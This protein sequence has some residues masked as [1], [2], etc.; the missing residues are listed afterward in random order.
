MEFR[1]AKNNQ[2]TFDQVLFE[3][4]EFYASQLIV[5]SLN[6]IFTHSLTLVSAPI[7]YG[8]VA[9][10]RRFLECTNAD[11]LW[12]RT[13]KQTL[14]DLW[15]RLCSELGQISPQLSE[16]LKLMK[17]NG[18][19][20]PLEVASAVESYLEI[21]TP[22]VI[23]LEGVH[24]VKGKII[25]LLIE[26]VKLRVRN[27]HIVLLADSFFP[28]DSEMLL[29]GLINHITPETLALNRQ[30]IM[31][32][33][34]AAQISLTEQETDF[35]LDYS[36]GW[37]AAIRFLIMCHR[38]QPSLSLLRPDDYDEPFLKAFEQEIVR[39]M[40][41][42]FI[43][44]LSYLADFTD[45][46]LE[47]AE[48]FQA[49]ESPAGESVLTILQMM[50]D[51][52][53]FI[54]YPPLDRRYRLHP[55]F[56]RVIQR[57]LIPSLPAT[58]F[59]EVCTRLGI[60]Y[61]RKTQYD[62]ALRC[63][64]QTGDDFAC[65]RVLCMIKR[66]QDLS[67]TPAIILKLFITFREAMMMNDRKQLSLPPAHDVLI[68]LVRYA[69]LLGDQTLYDEILTWIDSSKKDLIPSEIL[70][71]YE[72]MRGLVPSQLHGKLLTIDD[73]KELA[74]LSSCFDIS[75]GATSLLFAL[76]EGVH[77]S[78]KREVLWKELAGEEIRSG[79][80]L[81]GAS[82]LLY[83]EKQ[84]M[85][86]SFVEAEIYLHA[87]IR[88][89][90]LAGN[91]GVWITACCTLARVLCVQGNMQ[92]AVKLLHEVRQELKQEGPSRLDATVDLCEFSL[93]ALQG[94]SAPENLFDEGEATLRL[95]TPALRELGCLKHLMLLNEGRFIEYI[96]QYMEEEQ[97]MPH[98]SPL[99]RVICGIGLAKA[100]EKV[101]QSQG[102]T[103]ALF[104]T[105]RI[106]REE[107]LYTPLIPFRNW[108]CTLPWKREDT[109]L[110]ETIKKLDA[111]CAGIPSGY[112]EIKDAENAPIAA[113]TLLTR[114]EAE[115]AGCLNEGLSNRE[116]AQ[117]LCISEN[118]VKSTL[119]KI[120]AKLGI[121]SRHAFVRAY[122][123]GP[124]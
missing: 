96:S 99:R 43:S 88:S 71:L 93:Y 70:H 52:F 97:N 27:L 54:S 121:S 25:N 80:L 87:A 38:S 103:E 109:L 5:S 53:H 34:Q 6:A 105:L 32:V 92:D 18:E 3:S 95:Y 85:A 21:F 100:R 73:E 55:I 118:T 122:F 98:Y 91:P 77:D 42:P 17:Q 86:G 110:I 44:L 82:A 62:S 106:A 22:L 111:I 101:G 48:F 12:Y 56:R 60:W 26:V 10:V 63:Y 11:V 123:P 36:E 90:R 13:Q 64:I 67:V 78:D 46:S 108:M 68:P 28:I 39:K 112:H 76:P 24:S 30:D 114:R 120:Y 15:D 9:A 57:V 104:E 107:A 29:R 51:H 89:S 20:K 61:E 81:A 72:K 119:K 124:T 94:L 2:I 31:R 50:T 115:V 59:K 19:P 40:P 84:Y 33:T 58:R 16:E 83:A 116:I 4:E 8:Q 102:A 79:N 7:G 74:V 37:L 45:F 35:V 14:D 69:A 41:S 65:L 49:F 47:E 117:R 66:F 23:V 113:L 1:P 75:Y